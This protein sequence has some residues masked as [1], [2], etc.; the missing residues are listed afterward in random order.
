MD[1]GK[2]NIENVGVLR[3]RFTYSFDKFVE[4]R[5]LQMKLGLKRENTSVSLSTWGYG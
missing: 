2:M 4:A 5:D 3:P 1:F